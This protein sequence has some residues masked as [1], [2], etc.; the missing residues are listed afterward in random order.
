MKKV[1]LLGMLVLVFLL[2]GCGTTTVY[3]TDEVQLAKDIIAKAGFESEMYQISE[4]RIDEFFACENAQKKIMF[5]GNGVHSDSFGIITLGTEKDAEKTLENV[6]GFLADYEKSFKDY[7]PKEADKISK[8]VVIQ[9]GKYVIFCVNPDPEKVQKL[10]DESIT[11]KEVKK[12]E[13]ENQGSSEDGEEPAAE[14][15]ALG[16]IDPAAE[17]YPTIKASGELKKY[18]GV[19]G[20]GNSGFELY[21]YVDGTASQYAKSVNAVAKKLEGKAKVYDMI[22]PLSSGV[23]L[24]DEY[25]G[26]INSDD[27][28]SAINKIFE[29]MDDSVIKVNIYDNLMKNRDKYI[30]FRTDHHWTALGAY[31]GYE[32]WCEAK[33]IIPISLDRHEKV[34]FKGFLGSFYNDTRKDKALGKTPDVVEAYY[35][36]SKDATLNYT[37]SGGKEVK[38]DVIHDV[39]DYPA[40]IKYSTFIAG[41]NSMTTIE[42]PNLDDGSKC[43]VIK[44]SFGNALVPFLV[45]HY[46]KIYVLDYRYWN[47]NLESF[48]KDKNIDDVIFLNNISMMRNSYLT[49]KIGQLVG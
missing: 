22:I 13:E 39:K 34:E 38:W 49:G 32:K 18:G 30:Y 45:D 42:N 25:Y 11:E 26:K 23:V 47:G 28:R 35:P 10:I 43:V 17:G 6:K 33:G 5:M 20:I 7:I 27:Q 29:K 37:S 8:A 1:L 36:I 9:K 41:D 24:P 21:N 44:E 40:G 15:T 14:P 46:S 12:G 16:N 19:V 3:D 4:D 48:V 31:Y 2:A